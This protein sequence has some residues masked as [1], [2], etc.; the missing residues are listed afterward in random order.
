[1]ENA[2]DSFLHNLLGIISTPGPTLGKLMEA[3]KWIPVFVLVALVSMVLIYV[4]IPVQMDNMIQN[5]DLTEEQIAMLR[6]TPTTRLLAAGFTVVAM[7]IHIGVGAFMIYLF[8]GIGGAD[9]VYGN[10]FSVSVNA[11]LIDT[12]LPG[13]INIICGLAG[14]KLWGDIGL[15]DIVPMEP[16]SFGFLLLSRFA[17]FSIWYIVAISAGIAV[18]AKM[19]FSKSLTIG[20][21][22]FLFNAVVTTGFHYLFTSIFKSVV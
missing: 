22:Y 2:S 15:A 17:L 16:E 11:S 5:Q 12:V 1:M 14:W 19:K 18:F 8:Y 20:I 9:G 13:I 3:K 4:I 6:S 21:I 10:F 7:F